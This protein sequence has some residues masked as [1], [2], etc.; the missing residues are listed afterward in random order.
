MPRDLHRKPFNDATLAKLELFRKYIDAWLGVFVG[1][2]RVTKKRIRIFDLFCG[3]GQDSSGQKGSPLLIL[4]ALQRL[5]AMIKQIGYQ[6]DVYFNDADQ[7]KIAELQQTIADA[8]LAL[9]PYTLHFSSKDFTAIFKELR[10]EM[11]DSANLLLLDQNGVRFFTA[12]IFH[13]IRTLSLTDTLVFMSSS[14]VMRFKDEPEINKYLEAHK[15]FVNN[16]PFHQVHRAIVDYYRSLLPQDT[17]YFLAPFSI[18]AGSNIHGVIFGSQSLKGL[19]KFLESA[20]SMDKLRGEADY[21]IDREDIREGEPSLFADMNKPKKTQ[22]FEQQFE[23][24]VLAGKLPTTGA[25]YDYVLQQGFL[26]KHANP[27]LRR[28]KKAGQIDGNITGI[29]YSALKLP[30]PIMVIRK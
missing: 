15:I 2:G 11:L 27:V 10:T 26:L 30:E 4:E 5:A 18:R 13:Q 12:D 20:W 28:L 29:E 6:V 7:D 17:E 25:I 22:L 9:G 3:P 1:S 19:Q 23:A 8:G 16:T 14:Y 24:E 21:D